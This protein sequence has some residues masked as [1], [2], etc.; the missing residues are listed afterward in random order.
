MAVS[1]TAGRAA[2]SMVSEA[3]TSF[4]RNAVTVVGCPI[5]GSKMELVCKLALDGSGR[6]QCGTNPATDAETWLELPL[7]RRSENPS[8]QGT[9]VTVVTVDV[10]VVEVIDVNVLEVWVVV[11]WV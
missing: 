10:L 1:S 7:I 4:S 3:E 8:E 2:V 11:E 5:A 6:N 9:A